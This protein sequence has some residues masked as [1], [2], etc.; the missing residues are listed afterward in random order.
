MLVYGSMQY[1]SRSSRAMGTLPMVSLKKSASMV[2]ARMV[3]SD[4]R[5]SSNLPK[6]VACLGYR[7]RTCSERI[8]WAWSCNISTGWISQIP[9]ISGQNRAIAF[10]QPTSLPSGVICLNR[11]RISWIVFISVC[12]ASSF[13]RR[14]LII[15]LSRIGDRS[16]GI[17][18]WAKFNKNNSFHDSYKR[19]IKIC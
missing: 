1:M 10:M 4:G 15:W 6:R 18:H 2:D 5:S 3:L 7:I 13:G 14:S 11:I 12:V 19:D 8:H 16:S 17:L 9:G